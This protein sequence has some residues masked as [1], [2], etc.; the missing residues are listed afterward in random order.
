MNRPVIQINSTPLDQAMD[1]ISYA[2]LALLIGIPLVYY[3]QLPDE[4]PR[5]FNGTGT[6]DAYGGKSALILLPAVGALLFV[7]VTFLERIPHHY[8]YPKEVTEENAEP[9]YTSAVRLMRSLKMV[10]TGGFAYIVWRTIQTALGQA[11]GLGPAFMPIFLGLTFGLTGYFTYRV[12]Q[13]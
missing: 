1:I 7:G 9:M 4:I 11:E 5:H 13:S 10:I 8:N 3:G 12:F 2:A 6:P